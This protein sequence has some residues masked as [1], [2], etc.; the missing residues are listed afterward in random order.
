[1]V[2]SLQIGAGICGVLRVNEVVTTEVNYL[3][4]SA[5]FRTPLSDQPGPFCEYDKHP[6]FAM[7]TE[8][9]LRKSLKSICPEELRLV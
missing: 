2:Y 5:N 9:I 4:D 3:F 7:M 8:L 1:M 6:W